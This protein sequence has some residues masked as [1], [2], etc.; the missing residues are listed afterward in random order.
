MVMGVLID[1]SYERRFL[2]YQ[3]GLGRSVVIPLFVTRDW[4]IGA[5][6]WENG[7]WLRA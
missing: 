7:G 5:A 3:H 1:A 6:V 2:D 4:M